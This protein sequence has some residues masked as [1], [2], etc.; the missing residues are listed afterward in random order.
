MSDAPLLELP[1]GPSI[2]VVTLDPAIER[3]PVSI[4]AQAEQL[5]H[6]LGA[7]CDRHNKPTPLIIFALD[8]ERIAGP[9]PVTPKQLVDLTVGGDA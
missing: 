2:M 4:R 3:L 1:D 9:T 8:G 6:Q 5:K 7:Y